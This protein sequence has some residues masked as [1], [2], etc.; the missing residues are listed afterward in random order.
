MDTS[1]EYSPPDSFSDSTYTTDQ[2]SLIQE[3]IEVIESKINSGECFIQTS[4]TKKYCQLQLA[5]ERDEHFACLFLDSQH[6]LISFEKLFRGTI[7]SANV[8]PRVVLRRALELNAAALIL[9]HNHPSGI[10]NP[11]QAD[12]AITKKLKAALEYV[13]VRILDHII[14]GTEGST[15]LAETGSI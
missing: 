2:K 15:S 10:T 3:A 9:T 4:T 12:I 1:L 8:Y 6:R 14:V 7:D 11:S 5:S 13:D